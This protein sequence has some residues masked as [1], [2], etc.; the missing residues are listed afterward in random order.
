MIPS[1]HTSWT[2]HLDGIADELLRLTVACDLR[3]DPPTLQR[4]MNND[5]T[6]CGTPNPVGFRKL[7]KLVMVT[8]D[9]LNKAMDRIGPDET[10]LILDAI[11]ERIEHQRELG[12]SGGAHS[13]AKFDARTE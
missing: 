2:R 5:A 4:I 8:Y 11:V 7:R 6:V 3:L 9:S 1:K 13:D 10:K 12:R